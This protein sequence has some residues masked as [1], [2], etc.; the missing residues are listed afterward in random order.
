MSMSTNV[1]PM[2]FPPM[3]MGS[4]DSSAGVAKAMI[5]FELFPITCL[6]LILMFRFSS[7]L[8][9]KRNDEFEVMNQLNIYNF[10]LLYTY[11][12]C[13]SSLVI[14]QTFDLAV[15]YAAVF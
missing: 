14:N 3:K 5:S 10:Y 2:G 4:V 15:N 13:I 6:R 7:K 1:Q 9:K 8:S 12:E 11:F